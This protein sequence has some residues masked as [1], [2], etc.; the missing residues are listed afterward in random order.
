M[1]ANDRTSSAAVVSSGQRLMMAWRWAMWTDLVRRSEP[2]FTPGPAVLLAFTALHGGNG[3]PAES[4]P[5]RALDTDPDSAV[6][7][8]LLHLVHRGIDP[9]TTTALI[10]VLTS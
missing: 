1:A 9:P 7:L 3:V 8:V 6:A 10:T 4:A 5:H 2:V